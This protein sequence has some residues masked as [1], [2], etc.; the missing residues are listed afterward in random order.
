M[1]T[2]KFSSSLAPVVAIAFIHFATGHAALAQHTADPDR[3]AADTEAQ[4]TDDERFE[5]IYSVMGASAVVNPHRDPRIPPDVPMSA[6]YAKGVARLGV[7][8][9]LQTDA[10]MGVTNPGYRPDDPGATAFPSS[11]LVGSSFNPVL[12]R[13]V[14]EAIAGRCF[15]GPHRTLGSVPAMKAIITGRAHVP[16][17]VRST[18]ATTM[19]SGTGKSSTGVPASACDMN[20]VQIG[21]AT[22]EPVSSRP[23]LRGR[24]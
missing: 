8:A 3:R 16:A 14:G 24:S 21:T 23:R 20:A 13:R 9:Q 5:M 18:G 12:A 17:L 6:G 11:I 4:M 15:A 10:S 2:L 7:P 1:L 22:R 19:R